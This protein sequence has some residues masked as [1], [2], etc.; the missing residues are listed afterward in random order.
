MILIPNLVG[1]ACLML[2]PVLTPTQLSNCTIQTSRAYVRIDG[3]PN[4][5]MGAQT[6]ANLLDVA[7]IGVS[8]S[9][10]T[11]N[12]T[13][14]NEAYGRIFNECSITLNANVDGIKVDGSYL[15]HERQLYTG[16][17]GKV[18][19]N[20]M[21]KFFT[22]TRNAS[23]LFPSQNVQ[24]SFYKLIEGSEWFIYLKSN[25]TELSWQ[26]S[27]IGRMVSHKYE[28]WH[29]I[30]ISLTN[31]LH[32]TDGWGNA[33][34]FQDIVNRLMASQENGNHGII[35]GTRVFYISDYLVSAT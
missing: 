7:S 17:Y 31:I 3:D 28:D 9:L 35:T 30:D 33:A 20:N 24:E 26:Y 29:G 25:K 12:G 32:A 8:M 6:G 10:M 1:N 23:S 13:L 21:L 15:Q 4:G 11:S 22:E 16:N 27:V 2:L 34:E 5:S 19:V 14:F 18:F